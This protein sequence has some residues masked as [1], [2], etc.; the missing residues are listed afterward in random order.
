M[1]C[2]GGYE[3]GS[4][5]LAD[6]AISSFE[7]ERHA[8]RWSGSEPV[9]ADES[10]SDTIARFTPDSVPA[11]QWAHIGPTVRRWA[12]AAAPESAYSA[13]TL[14]S[15]ATQLVVWTES[16]GL[17]LKAD[18]IL[19]PDVIDR[20]VT[21]GCAQLADGTRLNY[22]RHLRVI[23]AAVLGHSIYPPR[24]LPIRRAGVLPPYSS[25]EIAALLSWARGLPTARFRHT[26]EGILALGLGAGLTSQEISRLVGT[27]IEAGPDGVFVSVIGDQAR[28]VPVLFRWEK[29]VAQLAREAGSGPVLMPDRTRIS[30]HQL[31]N[32]MARCPSGDAPVLDTGRLRSSWIC[33]HLA[34]GTDIRALEAASGVKALQVVK[35][36]AHV[37]AL[38]P[39]VALGQLRGGAR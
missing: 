8:P 21:E 6:E 18:T 12:E 3:E 36:L 38:D 5:K 17:P 13:R 7:R 37:P 14:L 10:V 23:G 11:S 1:L 27:D 25:I 24:P 16:I 19:H 28:L 35:Y 4:G 20:F 30:R 2:R 29:A 15:I 31:K 9:R 22:R 33:H 32:F 39:E 34:V 26:A